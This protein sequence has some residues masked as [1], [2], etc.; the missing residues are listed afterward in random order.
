MVMKGGQAPEGYE[1]R[2]GVD[3]GGD[4]SVMGYGGR[5]EVVDHRNDVERP[6][7]EMNL[8]N[9]ANHNQYC[10]TNQSICLRPHA[11][12]QAAQRR[13]SNSE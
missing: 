12:N 8:A 13:K 7:M 11:P 4:G 3:G 1:L 9:F 6:R 5:G 10:T 2:R